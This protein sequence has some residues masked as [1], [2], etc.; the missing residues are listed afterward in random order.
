[1]GE[2]VDS[3]SG[4]DIRLG[5][6]RAVRAF[7]LLGEAE[8]R[9]HGVAPEKCTCMRV[10][11]VDAVLDIVGGS[12]GSRRLG[13][14]VVHHLSRRG[15]GR[16]GSSG[17]RALPV[18]APAT[19]I[20][21]EGLEIASADRFEGEATT[22][23]G[24][25]CS[26]LSSGVPPDR[27]R[28]SAA[29]G[30]GSARSQAVSNAAAHS[31][32]RGCERGRARRVARHDVD[33]MS[34]EY[35]E[36]LRQAL[37]QAGA[38][39]VQTWPVQMKKGRQGFRVEAMGARGACGGGDGRAVPPQHHGRRLR[40]IAERATLPRHQLTVR[41]DGVAVR[42][43]VGWRECRVKPEYD[44]V[45]AAAQAL[46]RAPLDV[47][48]RCGARRRGSHREIQGV[49]VPTLRSAAVF[50]SPQSRSR[51]RHSSSSKRRTVGR[52]RNAT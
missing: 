22:P 43:S 32:R 11:A 27:W 16:A 17:A 30:R 21:I 46:G 23:R 51:W 5:E 8:G 49:N 34:P 14:E 40:W 42:S 33:D 1:M 37:V 36:P 2:L 15:W 45:L 47:A 44:D 41:L 13:V 26:V 29:G 7:Q 3:S 18:P 48:R 4:A 19:A 25:S 12:K 50:L 39:D 24:R 10:G 52:S 31:P 20:L 6:E 35:V 38:L 28:W 9:V